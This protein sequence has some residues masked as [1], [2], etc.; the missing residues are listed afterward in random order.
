MR[1]RAI[2]LWALAGLAILT[3]VE[4]AFAWDLSTPVWTQT[5]TMLCRATDYHVCAF[6]GACQRRQPTAVWHFDFDRDL[7]TYQGISFQERIVARDVRSVSASG[8]RMVL[9]LSSGRVMELRYSDY[10]DITGWS[11]AVPE[12][13]STGSGRE[14]VTF[15]WQCN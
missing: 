13:A 3:S 5:R 14:V 4:K 7:V 9:L 10:G 15:Y 6:Y 11:V 1:R 8:L 2:V 12:H